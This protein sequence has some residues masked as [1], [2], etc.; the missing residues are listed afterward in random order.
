MGSAGKVV[1][2]PVE[3]Q[4]LIKMITQILDPITG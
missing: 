3:F 4:G 1:K 2:D